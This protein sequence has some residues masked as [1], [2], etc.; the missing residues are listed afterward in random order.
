MRKRKQRKGVLTIEASIAYSIFLIVIVTILYIMRIVYTYGLI[1]HAAA[2]TAKELSQYTYIYQISGLSDMNQGVQ[3]ATEERTDQFDS[4]VGKIVD[5]YEKLTNGD[6][7]GVAD[8]EYDGTISPKEILK[9]VAAV[10]IGKGGA[11]VNQL[12]FKEMVRP[13]MGVYIGADS[14]GNDADARLR[15][16]GIKGGLDGLDLNCSSF[17]EDGITIDLVVCY[18]LDPIMP[19]DIMPEMN[20]MNRAYVRGMNGVAVFEHGSEEETTD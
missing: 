13:L 20:F 14:K 17:C 10:L 5:L 4:D 9:N 2:Q 16:L 12:L 1:Q 3:D 11:E 19:I 8:W 6:V 18:T 7:E 15:M